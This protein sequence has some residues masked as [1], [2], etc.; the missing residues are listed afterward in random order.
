MSRI[1]VCVVLDILF[2]GPS[3]C[4]RIVLMALS[5]VASFRVLFAEVLPLRLELFKDSVEADLLT[6]LLF[7]WFLE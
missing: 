3:D 4:F 7:E 5:I 2:D 6:M 1:V